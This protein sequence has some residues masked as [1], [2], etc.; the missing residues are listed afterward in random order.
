MGD[1]PEFLMIVIII[2]FIIYD[3]IQNIWI[4]NIR[5]LASLGLNPSP[6]LPFSSR[7]LF[8]HTFLPLSFSDKEE[9]DNPLGPLEE[10]HW[11]VPW[12]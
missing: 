9:D 4:I 10:L 6:F 5:F 2:I 7:D 3:N 8:V 1:H 12:A 11:L